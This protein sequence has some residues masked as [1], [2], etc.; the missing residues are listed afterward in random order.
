MYVYEIFMLLI[1]PFSWDFYLVGSV[2]TFGFI[3]GSA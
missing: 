3:D 1:N 2:E